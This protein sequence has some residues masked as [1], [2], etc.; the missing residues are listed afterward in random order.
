[1]IQAG[2]IGAAGLSG[3]ELM[4][5]LHRHDQ[6]EIKMVTS[7]KHQGIPVNQ[8]FPEISGIPLAFEAHDASVEGC[9]VVFLAVP[10]SASLEAVPRL[11]K[12][13]VKVVDLSGVFRLKSIPEFEKFYE[14]KHT[15]TEELSQAVFGLPE[16]FGEAIKGARLV[17]NPGCYP[18]GALLGMLPFGEW[19]GTLAS[20]PLVDAKSGVSGAGG[21]V[22]EDGFSFM[23]VNENFRAYKVFGHQHTPEIESYLAELTPF[24]P[25]TQGKLR[26]TPHMLP[27]ARGILSSIYLSFQKPLDPAAVR[28]KF[29][30][31]AEGKPFFTL[32]PDGMDATLK[33]T[34]GTNQ[35]VAGL[36]HDETHQNWVVV[37]SIDNLLKGAAGQAVQNMNLMFSLEET[38]GLL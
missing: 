27:I 33:M 2:I 24:S 21:R 3:Q 5:I 38:A 18:T 37:T 28:E 8:A 25:K 1:M 23:D 14:L 17:G 36:H 35:C 29:N 19:M 15:A 7:G 6:V 9:D 34:Q 22:E 31:F 4:K 13:G 26:F 20:P 30:Q 32:L 12:A 11:L 10:N 16:A